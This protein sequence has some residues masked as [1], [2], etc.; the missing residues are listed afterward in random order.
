MTIDDAIKQIRAGI[1]NRTI[2]DRQA[3]KF[4]EELMDIVAVAITC[5]AG[6]YTVEKEVDMA[7]L[8]ICSTEVQN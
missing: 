2:T 5:V 3:A 4:Y 1:L 6:D 8:E 7:F